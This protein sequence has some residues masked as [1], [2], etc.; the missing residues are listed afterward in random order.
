VAINA[1]RFW[2]KV[3]KSDGCWLWTAS[4]DGKGYGK[5]LV[6][7]GL[8]QAHRISWQLHTGISP[9]AL[10]VCHTCDNPPCV[11]PDH[12]FAGTA[13]DNIMD[14]LSKGRRPAHYD[15]VRV[16]HCPRGH[17]YTPANTRTYKNSRSCKRCNADRELAKYRARQDVTHV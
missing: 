8:Q 12:L 11:R 6:D 1:E 17:E 15:I 9:G 4:T 7:G 16:T 14:M 2:A 10:D 3:Q 13:L 5:M